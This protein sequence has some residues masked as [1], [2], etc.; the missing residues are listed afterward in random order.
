MPAAVDQC[1]RGHDTR[2]AASRD[3]QGHC[4]ACLRD[5]RVSNRMKLAVA[6]ALEGVGIR[7]IDDEGL[8]VEAID[9]ARQIASKFEKSL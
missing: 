6:N 1:P 9:V 8:P 4:K 5:R 2:T 3:T 7:F